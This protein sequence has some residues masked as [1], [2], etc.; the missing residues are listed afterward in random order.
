MGL[1]GHICRVLIGLT[2]APMGL[3]QDPVEAARVRWAVG[4]DTGDMTTMKC[5]GD[6]HRCFEESNQGGTLSRA[7]SRGL[8]PSNGPW[9]TMPMEES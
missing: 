2:W 3:N 6:S 9:D 1:K 8:H 4:Q 7:S 5:N